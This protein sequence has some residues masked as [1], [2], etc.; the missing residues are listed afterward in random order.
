MRLVFAFNH[1]E[2]VRAF[3]EAARLD[4][5]CAM[6]YWGIAY[7]HGPHV[8]AGM[9]SASGVQA[10]AAVRKA[11]QLAAR[12]SARERAYIDALAKR[13]AAIPPAN[14]AHLDSAYESAMAKIAQR[15]SEDLDALS[16]Y[17]EAKMD[18]RP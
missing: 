9:D 6:C 5:S 14:R 16:L 3:S 17:A 18:L 12:A 10:Y 8:N 1:G 4:P 11:R 2:A 15:Y 13:Y 7:A